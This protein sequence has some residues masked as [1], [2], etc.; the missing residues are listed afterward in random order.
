MRVSFVFAELCFAC[1]TQNVDEFVTDAFLNRRSCGPEILTG[2]EV[3][4]VLHHVLTNG[5]GHGKA[6]VGVDIGAAAR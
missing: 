2:I 6:Q 4:G 3:I 5:G 1:A